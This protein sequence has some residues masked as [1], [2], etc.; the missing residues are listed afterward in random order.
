MAARNTSDTDVAIQK[1]GPK[2]MCHTESVPR[3]DE[4]FLSNYLSLP[5]ETNKS[6][7]LRAKLDTGAQGNIL[8]MILSHQTYP[9]HWHRR[10]VN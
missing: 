3:R 4:V 8:P 6:T 2:L 10:T 5:Q 7:R 1:P 9:H